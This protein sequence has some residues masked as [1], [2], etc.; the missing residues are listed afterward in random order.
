[1]VRIYRSTG[2]LKKRDTGSHYVRKRDH[3]KEDAMWE[4]HSIFLSL[5]CISRL[6]RAYSA[7]LRRQAQE[8]YN[9]VLGG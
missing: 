5:F 1:M 9:W 8:G 7:L 3:G 2:S 6:R 4:E